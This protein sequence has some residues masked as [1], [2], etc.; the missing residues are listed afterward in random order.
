M[1]ALLMQGVAD[2]AALAEESAD[3][4]SETAAVS[5]EWLAAVEDAFP[6]GSQAWPYE[7]PRSCHW[8]ATMEPHGTLGQLDGRIPSGWLYRYIRFQ[9]S[10]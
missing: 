6:Q 8:L 5:G 1:M 9:H 10:M 2:D 4:L 7:P 3:A